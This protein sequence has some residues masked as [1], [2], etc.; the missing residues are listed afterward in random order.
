[1]LQAVLMFLWWIGL[2]T[3]NEFFN[4][5]QFPE[6]DKV[7]FLSFFIP[8]ILVVGVLSV[9]RAY[10]DRRILEYII[11]GGFSYAALYCMNAT[12]LTGGGYLATTVM[13][14]GLCY[15]LFLV[16]DKKVFKES[17]SNSF[18]VNGIKTLVQILCVWTIT[19]VVFPWI[20]LEAFGNNF[21]VSESY[22]T[23]GYCLLAVFSLFGLYSAYTMVRHGNGT[24]LP[25]DQTKRLVVK[26]PYRYVRNPMAIAG[27]GQGIAVSLLL[28]SVHIF[29]YTLVGAVL[30]QFVVRP[31]EEKNMAARFGSEYERYRNEVR[32]WIPR[33]GK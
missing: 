21:S 29:I 25:L 8:D 17:K 23:M 31:I 27:L 13:T 5:F 22:Q 3:S 20:I 30:W 33:F 7:A 6:I 1:M 32:C 28:G 9:V 15:N 16:F 24:P 12:Y 19:L 18:P 14:L 2:Y 4:A 26:G 11:L 10:Y